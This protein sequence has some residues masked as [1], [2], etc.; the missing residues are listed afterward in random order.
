VSGGATVRR[1]IRGVCLVAAI[2]L[3]AG[4][5]SLGRSKGGSHGQTP[6]RDSLEDYIG[7]VRRLSTASKPTRPRASSI[8]AENPDLRA[9]L[10]ALAAQATPASHRR[11]AEAYRRTGV[12]D[13]AYDHYVAAR[14]LDSEDAAAY[15]GLAR[16]W[17]DWG[18]PDLGV[19][20]AR[21]AIYHAPAW[22]TAHNTLGTLLNA[23]GQMAEARRAFERA[24]GLD[25]EAAYVWTNLCYQ[26]FQMG[27]LTQAVA[28]CRRAL[29]LEPGL[30]AAHHN[31]ALAYAAAGDLDAARRELWAANADEAVRHFNAGVVLSASRRYGEAARS[32]DAAYALRPGWTYAADRARQARRLAE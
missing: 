18:V 15:E 5:A 29:S 26:S 31:L 11:V 16:I 32:F 28:S 3:A 10:D 7:K 24:L 12:L 1:R 6:P 27:E 20:D 17:R 22:P 2:L 14:D 19:G 23:L 25:P 21:R 30:V 8:E 13:L 9:A 4:C